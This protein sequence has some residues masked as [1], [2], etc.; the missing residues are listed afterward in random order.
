MKCL[1]CLLR[2]ENL[3]YGVNCA[4]LVL[5]SEE[6]LLSLHSLLLLLRQRRARARTHSLTRRE[7]RTQSKPEV[8]KAGLLFLYK[9]HLRLL[10]INWNI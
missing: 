1:R 7:A 9:L 6:L 3:T 4:A 10:F 2:V 8:P 5:F